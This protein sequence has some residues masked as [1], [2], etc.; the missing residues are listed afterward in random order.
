MTENLQDKSI[1]HIFNSKSTLD[2]TTVENLPIG[3]FGDFYNHALTFLVIN[4]NDLKNVKQIFNKNNLRIKKIFI[5][6]F[7][8][9]IQLISNYQN[10]ETFFNIKIGEEN[11]HLSFFDNSAFRFNEN[12]NFGSNIILKDITKV[13]SINNEI[14]RKI[15]EDKIFFK[16]DFSDDEIIDKKYFPNSTQRK[17]RKK[18]VL[19]IVKARVEEIVNIVFKNNINLK[20]LKPKKGKVFITLKDKDISKNFI[21]IFKFYF[22]NN[23]NLEFHLIDGFDLDSTT[24]AAMNLSSY[25]W[26]KKQFHYSKQKFYNYKDIY[27]FLDNFLFFFETFVVLI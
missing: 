4:N 14:L 25:G 3:L 16:N 17:I 10:S 9:G 18:L 19:D 15:L 27:Y 13:C 1:I 20:F 21:D 22:S 8:E 11:S 23:E 6:D 7:V 12:F 24:T 2:G 5:K 26:K